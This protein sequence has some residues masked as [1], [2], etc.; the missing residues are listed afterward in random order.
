MDFGIP[1]LVEIP[2]T[3]ESAALCRELGLQFMEINMSFPQYQ[4]EVMDVDK[5]N[6]IREKYG[7]YFTVHI[8]EALDPCSV[9]RG[10]AKVYTD[11]ML[12]TIRLARAVGIPTLNM[13]L[14]R[15]IYVTLPGR[16]TYVY[17][18]NEELYLDAMRTF[19]DTVSD[20]IGGSGIRVCVENT[21]GYDLPFLRNAVELLLESPAFMLTLDVGHDH[22][23]NNIDLPLIL[24]HRD[25]LS[26]MHMHD[27]KGTSVHLAL[28]DGELDKDHFL[29]LAE[30]CG[31][32]TVLETKTVDALRQSAAWLRSAGY[33]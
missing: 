29:K 5:L 26:H 27:A 11:T 7:I 2:D 15:G 21:D 28:G 20:A 17:A 1:T 16:R 14:L 8:D 3:G 22:A 19:R 31:C 24:S 4:P 30:E 9:N 25:R 12:K 6:R 13:H 32:R 10:I 23:I 18:E 33:L